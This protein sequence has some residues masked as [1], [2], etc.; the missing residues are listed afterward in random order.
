MSTGLILAQDRSL[1]LNGLSKDSGAPS[2]ISN[3]K[4][5][6][7][8]VFS[9]HDQY[10]LKQQLQSLAKYVQDCSSRLVE[11]T[12]NRFLRDLAFTLGERR[13][14]LACRASLTAHS[15]DELISTLQSGCSEV[16]SFLPSGKPQIGFI[17][18]GQGAQWAKMGIELHQYRVFR[19]SVENS[20]EYLRSALGCPWSAMEQ[21][22]HHE[23]QSNINL[24]EYSQPL[25][26]ILQI[27]IVDLLESW[28][29]VPSAIAGHSSGEIAAAYCLG[30]LTKEDALK[31]TYHRGLLSSQIKNILPTQR[32]AMMAVAASESQAQDWI[33]RLS[34]GEVVLACI[35][36]PS[37]V[38]LSGDASGIEELQTI[39][40]KEGIFARML[41]VDTAYHSPHMEIIAA[42]YLEAIKEIQTLSRQSRK[43]FSAVTGCL[44]DPSE[45][46]P[47]NWV[48]NLMSP[49]L[50]YDATRALLQS[51]QAERQLTEAS[52]DI[53]LEIG[54]HAALQGPIGQ[55]LK[56]HSIDNVVYQ[57]VLLRGRNGTES[58]LTAV[59][60]LLCQGVPAD[61]SRI[62]NDANDYCYCQPCP[63]VDLPSYRWNHSRSF[64]S[65]SRI[66]KQYRSRENPRSSLLGALCPAFGENE[67]LWRGFLRISE[68]PW[69]QDHKIQE[70]ILYPAAGYIVMAVE[71]ACQIAAKENAIECL[72]LREVQI[73]T[74]A[75][76]TED[77]ELECILQF[78]PH[79]QGTHDSSSAWME[80]TVSTCVSGQGLQQNCS[81][82][83]LIE[84]NSEEGTS[85]SFE[86]K[87]DDQAS[88]EQY[89]RVGKL[90]HISED[91][92]DFYQ[93]LAASGLNYG[94]ALRNV[95]QVF[96]SSGKSRCSVDVPDHGFVATTE[97]DHR[98]HIIHPATLDAI[99]HLVFAA[100]KDDNGRLK[101]GVIPNSIGEM[102]ISATTPSVVGARLVGSCA[103]RQHGARGVMAE[104]VMLDEGLSRPV[105]TMNE[106]QWEA[107]SGLS[108]PM[109]EEIEPAAR[110]IFS[111]LIWKP[112]I[113]LLSS[114]QQLEILKAATIEA[115]APLP[116]ERIYRMEMLAN[117]YICRVLDR[118]SLEMVQASHL[119][120]LYRWM[121]DQALL[122]S[123]EGLDKRTAD[124][125]QA[126]LESDGADGETLCQIGKNLESIVLGKLDATELPLDENIM[127]GLLSNIRGLDECYD[128]IREVGL[129]SV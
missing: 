55:I 21:I 112:A 14:R 7:I 113:E 18:T 45:L 68:Q 125:F 64:F 5:V 80:F 27:A 48:R 26:T 91:P 83:L 90:C 76:V 85:M 57:P 34:H 28:N 99:F 98:T 124:L 88:R 67:K 62:N 78:R 6:R 32:G 106:F 126:D 31:V 82:L 25:C 120:D 103:A 89:S 54:P 105:V 93:D 97:Q 20:D 117:F 16:L 53:L 61:L 118:V 24:P 50:F 52:P 81:G 86:N 12:R 58:A 10:G 33:A 15:T 36:S 22:C 111:K 9:A 110:K 59:G 109:D 42:Q 102:T 63:L 72:R 60:A 84:Y 19:E 44:V 70:S 116:T 114:N 46:G 38:T 23:S 75:V 73:S 65:E 128:Q 43:M 127:D 108:D 39:L 30:A 49:V 94:P 119:Q 71:A 123:H 87:M 104:I 107:F 69:I 66:S 74:P 95:S 79:L 3:E 47:M 4:R 17:F 96:R 11:K 122:R 100:H 51:M 41:K 8:F 77:S 129:L 115:L 40:K 92:K 35:N 121:H 101:E 56:S 13:S 29:I 1:A 2:K 37:S